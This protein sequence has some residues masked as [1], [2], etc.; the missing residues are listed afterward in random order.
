[1][2]APFKQPLIEEVLAEACVSISGLKKNPGAVVAEAQRRQVAILNRNRPVAY[3][4]SPEVWEHLC[5][6][7]ADQRLIRDAQD[8]L[9]AI[10]NGDGETVEVELDRYL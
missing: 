9:N 7:V 1:M 10:G 4:I 5:D 2:N 6:L 8:E 3:V